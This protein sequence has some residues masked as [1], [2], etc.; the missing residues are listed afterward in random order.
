M[1]KDVLSNVFLITP[2]YCLG[3]GLLRMA[4]NYFVSDVFQIF[5]IDVYQNPYGSNMLFWHYIVMATEGAIFFALVLLVE[6]RLICNK[7]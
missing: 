2:Q 6:S 3:D 4:R 5:R 7:Q 1:V